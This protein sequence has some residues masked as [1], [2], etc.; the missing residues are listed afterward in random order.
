LVFGG[1]LQPLYDLRVLSEYR[2]VLARPKLRIESGQREILLTQISSEGIQV[3]AE[4]LSNSLPDPSDEMFLEIALAGSAECLIT[5]NLR[6][7]PVEKCCGMK[8][9]NPGD[10]INFYADQKKQ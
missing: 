3:A 10:F 5:G 2:E 8:V 9:L 1:H 6:H 4:P 7:F